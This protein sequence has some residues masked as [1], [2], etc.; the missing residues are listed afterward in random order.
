MGNKLDILLETARFLGESV[1]KARKAA[2]DEIS[3][4]SS[5]G[6]RWPTPRA[7]L[8]NLLR[9]T[10]TPSQSPR[11]VRENAPRVTN[12]TEVSRVQPEPPEPPASETA[13]SPEPSSEPG[14]TSLHTNP[15]INILSRRSRN[16]L[17][18]AGIITLEDLQAKSPEDLLELPGFGV[19]CL[20]EVDKFLEANGAMRTIGIEVPESEEE[21]FVEK[22]IGFEGLQERTRNMLQDIGISTANELGAWSLREMLEA[23]DYEETMSED[24]GILSRLTRPPDQDDLLAFLFASGV[25]REALEQVSDTGTSDFFDKTMELQEQVRS[26]IERGTLH[27]QAA[28]DWAPL[29]AVNHTF[30][31]SGQ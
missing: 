9:R 4:R 31:A 28:L 6:K 24:L 10:R 18:R 19:K 29:Q 15:W 1:S 20:S 3:R 17:D 13:H 26:Q 16:C 8:E 22:A 2:A 27:G 12:V 7:T 23:A 21:L 30:P 11:S 14:F 25:V 5:E